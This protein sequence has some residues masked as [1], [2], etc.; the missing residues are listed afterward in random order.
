MRNLL[1]GKLG[2]G[3]V[4]LPTEQDPRGVCGTCR[5]FVDDPRE[6]DQEMRFLS[7][8]GRVD[9]RTSERLTDV[10]GLQSFGDGVGRTQIQYTDDPKSDHVAMFVAL[11]HRFR[12]DPTGWGMCEKAVGGAALTHRD[13]GK[14]ADDTGRRTNQCPVWQGKS[15]METLIGRVV[16]SKRWRERMERARLLHAKPTAFFQECPWHAGREFTR[17]CGRAR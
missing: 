17:C 9:L 5:F 3:L 14:E 11:A 7:A 12:V 15:R 16:R 6:I 10:A 2:V 13:C 8:G 1:P 4:T